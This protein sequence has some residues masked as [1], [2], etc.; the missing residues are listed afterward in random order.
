[1]GGVVLPEVE[2]CHGVCAHGQPGHGHQQGGD[3]VEELV[4][5][6]TQP[7]N[8]VRPAHLHT[9]ALKQRFA[10]I[11]QSQSRPLLSIS[12]TFK[13]KLGKPSLKKPF[14]Y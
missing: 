2:V 10:K 4:G 5:E 9:R 11:S 13:N 12:I 14:S 3:V 8:T 6:V 7:P 1:M